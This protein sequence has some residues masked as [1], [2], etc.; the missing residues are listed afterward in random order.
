MR[1]DSVKMNDK[2]ELMDTVEVGACVVVTEVWVAFALILVE[3]E[4]SLTLVGKEMMILLL[5][6]IDVGDPV[7]E[8]E[9]GIETEIELDTPGE[10]LETPEETGSELA[11]E[12]DGVDE[13]G[14]MMLVK[15]EMIVGMM[16]PPPLLVEVGDDDVGTE[17]G[18][19]V[20]DPGVD[21]GGGGRSVEMI[22]GRM[23]PPPLLDELDADVGTELGEP[24]PV[25]E[26]GVGVAEVDDEGDRTLVN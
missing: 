20:I 12:L 6:S 23:P 10:E 3:V 18:A 2:S 19:E 1:D 16:P 13:G 22:L 8:T 21:E 11:E 9:V 17:D 25:S 4:L 24:E 14:V 26:V 15:L 5:E 7:M